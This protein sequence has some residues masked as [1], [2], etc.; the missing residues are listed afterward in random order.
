MSSIFD[1]SKGIGDFIRHVNRYLFRTFEAEKFITGMFLDFN[2]RKGKMTICD[3]GHSY[4]YLYRGGRLS[5]I[6]TN[7]SNLPIGIVPENDPVLNK[8][9]L[10]PNDIIL[11]PTDGLLEQEN[12]NGAL[13]TPER[14]QSIIRKNQHRQ[15][16]DIHT[17]LIQDFD[18]FRGAA[19]LHDDVTYVLLKYFENHEDDNL[20]V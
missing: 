17:E 12:L 4:I 20:G 13:Y 7:T 11:I 6:K 1:F 2:S 15:L 19:H 8:M 9:R 18:R 3:M 16:D 10:Q 14:I 5:R